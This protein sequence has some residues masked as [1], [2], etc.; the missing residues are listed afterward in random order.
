MRK[1]PLRLFSLK[2]IQEHGFGDTEV[3]IDEWGFATGGFLNREECPSLMFRETEKFASYYVK[4]ISEFIKNDFHMST[5]MICLSGQHEMVEDFSGFRNFFTLNFIAKPIYN[6]HIMASRLEDGLLAAETENENLHVIPTKGENGDYAILLTYASEYFDEDLPAITEKLA[7]SEDVSKRE[8]EIYCIDKTH[9]N[10]YALALKK[11]M[12]IP[13]EEQLKSLRDEG[14]LKPL[15]A[16]TAD[17]ITLDL[18]ANATY[19]VTV[20]GEEK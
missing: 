4:L 19:L 16:G 20:K 9:T 8:I 12:L 1:N 18:T 14:I 17:E 7:F 5:L 15:Y 6:A 11:D 3:V 10:P 2:N 13:N